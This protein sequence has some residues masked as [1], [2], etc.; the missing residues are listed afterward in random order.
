MKLTIYSGGDA[1][2]QAPR[3]S[4]A[5][6]ATPDVKLFVYHFSDPDALPIPGIPIASDAPGSLGGKRNRAKIG[7]LTW[8]SDIATLCSY[9]FRRDTLRFQPTQEQHTYSNSA[10]RHHARLLDFFCHKLRSQ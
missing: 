9:P 10:E 5:Q 7:L 6:K 8:A 2:I 4:F 3:R 1:L